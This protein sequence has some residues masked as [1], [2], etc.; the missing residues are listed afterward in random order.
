M[1]HPEFAIE[2]FLA[3]FLQNRKEDLMPRYIVE[4]DIPEIGSAGQDALARAAQKSNSALAGMKEQ[5][6]NIQWDHSYVADNKT[7][8][9]YLADDESLVR[10]HAQKSGFPAN[11]ITEVR[12][13]IDPVTAEGS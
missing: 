10:E 9:V 8:C 1:V 5:K 4:R 11:K 2:A 6:K 12:A 13:V 7:F 3:Q